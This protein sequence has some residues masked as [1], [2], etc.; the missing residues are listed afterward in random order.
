MTKIALILIVLLLPVCV[1]AECEKN[2]TGREKNLGEIQSKL[3]CLS[4]E[5]SKI[6]RELDSK[7]SEL[8]KQEEINKTISGRLEQAEKRADKL[9][10]QLKDKPV[11]ITATH[12]VGGCIAPDGTVG[13]VQLEVGIFNNDRD[14]TPHGYR[15]DG[16]REPGAWLISTTQLERVQI[17]TTSWKEKRFGARWTCIK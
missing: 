15:Q 8:R 6:K 2:I 17:G 1:L 7:V 9:A 10:G 5:N 14:K 4:A 16:V 11:V 12:P 13:K 3:D